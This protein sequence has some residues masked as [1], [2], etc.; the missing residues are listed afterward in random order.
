[1][2]LNTICHGCVLTILTRLPRLKKNREELFGLKNK[3]RTLETI[4]ISVGLR[5]WAIQVCPLLSVIGIL[6]VL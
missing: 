1:M 3:C 5:I 4:R 6:M 2:P